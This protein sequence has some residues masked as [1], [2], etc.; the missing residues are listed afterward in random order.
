MNRRDTV[1]AL[2]ALASVPFATALP[3]L[4][5]S[6]GKVIRLGILV[7]G[8]LEQR[9]GLDQA[10]MEG[11]RS[12][13]YVEGKNL[14][15]ERRYGHGMTGMAGQGMAEHGMGQQLPKFAGE[16]A[17]MKLDAIV[18]SCAPSTHAAK[19]ATSTIPIVMASVSDPVAQGLIASLAKPGGNITGL[20]SQAD[21]LLPKRL[22]QLASILPPKTPIAVLANSRNPV[23]APMWQK[24]KDA[25][26]KLNLRLLLVKTDDEAGLPVAFN[27]IVG[28]RAKA[29][30]VLPDDPMGF[31]MRARIVAFAADRR[32]PDFYWAS[33]FVEAGG[34][35]SY[36]ANLRNSYADATAYIEKVVKGAKPA[37]LPVAQPTRFELVVNQK[38]AMS[39]G[40]KIPQSILARADRVI[41]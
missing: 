11:L 18:T 34:L 17:G 6:P 39:L 20:S 31:N 9:G 23:H 19:A 40:L 2:L 41:E 33:E 27:A 14:V 15:V 4:A 8:T 13:G 12:H 28:A 3:G 25:A 29:L 37:A 36:G 30:F 32:M 35:L 26:G 21:E 7:S 1:R 5:Q 16:L 38:T 24:L 10:M 22:E